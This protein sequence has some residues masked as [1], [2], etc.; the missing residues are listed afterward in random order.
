MPRGRDREDAR[1]RVLPV[2]DTIAAAQQ[3][4]LES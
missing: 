3:E 4:E 1:A 2:I